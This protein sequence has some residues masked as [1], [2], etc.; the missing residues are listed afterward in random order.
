MLY[1]ASGGSIDWAHGEA[2]ITFATSLELRDKGMM[3]IPVKIRYA[4]HWGMYIVDLYYR[5]AIYLKRAKFE[6]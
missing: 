5:N 4:C 2:G 1:V 6:F 3:G